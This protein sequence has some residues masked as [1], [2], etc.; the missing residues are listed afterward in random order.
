MEL[1]GE[2]RERDYP[3]GATVFS[4]GDSDDCLYLIVDGTVRV[5]TGE[6][7]L[8]ELG[9]KSSFGEIAVF[10]GDIIRLSEKFE[11]LL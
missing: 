11:R 10:H 4:E 6:T 2:V 8:S 3:A 9:P 1:A 5:T 7:L